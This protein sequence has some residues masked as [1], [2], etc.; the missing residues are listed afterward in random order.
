M[1]AAG[2]RWTLG[3][4]D[5]AVH[6]ALVAHRIDAPASDLA[7]GWR[8]LDIDA[9][10]LGPD[11]ALQR[12]SRGD[13]ALMRVDVR[14]TLDGV[15]AGLSV[16]PALRIAGVR[17]LNPP[18]ALIGAHDKVETARR[19]RR[20]GLPHPHTAPIFAGA[21]PPDIEPPVVVK[22]RFGSQGREVHLCATE[23]DLRHCLAV[24][25]ERGWYRRSGGVIQSLVPAA[26]RECRV[27][28]AGGRPVACAERI[29][30]RGDW[31]TSPAQRFR[32]V[33]GA[34]AT[35]ALDLA[36]AAAG[37]IG[38]D[39]VSVDLLPDGTGHVVLDVNAVA[40]LDPQHALFGGDLFAEAA[41]AL[42]LEGHRRR[43]TPSGAGATAVGAPGR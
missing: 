32:A 22:P 42:G 27:T 2:R 38:G 11:A 33:R 7:A 15:E 1:A 34:P 19:L 26:S 21:R 8:A 18:W 29:V 5:C 10:V 28:V 16:V 37:S 14:P 43:R 17:I 4:K 30:S 24:L 23:T 20:A 25:E 36:V 41:S 9:R 31:R 35:E 3:G 13:V 39:L 40:I 6:V 12:L